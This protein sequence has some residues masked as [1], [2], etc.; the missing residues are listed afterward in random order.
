MLQYELVES[1][2]IFSGYVFDVKVDKISY[3]GK[4]KHNRE[5]VIHHGGAVV[6]P[7]LSNNKIIFVK[8]YRYPLQKAIIELPAG[9][10]NKGEDPLLCAT[11]ELQEETGYTTS[12]ISKLGS[13]YTSPGFCTE[14][15]H[16]F[17]AEDLIPGPHN[18][19]IGELDMEL[20]ELDFSQV[21]NLIANGELKD[22]KSI[23][24]IT[25][26]FMQRNI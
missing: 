10:L 19:E 6:L 7:L 2:T 18:R 20:L 23:A 9:K 25:M 8:Q 4:D 14:E 26:F 5:V 11:R 13:I 15:L 3:N 24:A 16:L 12:K 1:K 21:K 17:L 22:A